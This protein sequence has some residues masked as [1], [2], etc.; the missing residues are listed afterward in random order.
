[1]IEFT[2]AQLADLTQLQDI[3]NELKTQ[4]VIIGAMA[5]KFHFPDIERY[6]ADIDLTVALDL[7]DFAE[8]ETRLTKLGWERDKKREHRW[9]GSGGTLID[10]LPAGT[11][12]RAAKM[13]I[14]P[15]SQF[16][17]SLVGFDHVFTEAEAIK[18]NES[19]TV[20]VASVLV[21]ALLKIVAFLD[22][23][24]ERQRD[25]DDLRGILSQYEE[26][27]DRLFSDDVQAANLAD[28]S[29]T[30]AFALGVDLRSL[31]TAE[32][33]AVVETFLARVSNEADALWALFVRAGR[34]WGDRVEEVARNQFAAFV[35][36][37]QRRMFQ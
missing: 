16:S 7:E 13:L 9:K 23:P 15:E 29:L 31:C 5:Y 17:M 25:L 1:M 32:E 22:R 19:F 33:I 8:L 4:L 27:S 26:G 6:T 14:W 11:K 18:I 36:G 34:Q 37:F 3:C 21:L 28:F 30:N 12:L 24:Y 20:N 2:E 10:L 35:Q